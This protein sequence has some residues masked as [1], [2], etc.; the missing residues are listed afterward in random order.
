MLMTP[1]GIAVIAYVVL[2]V[3]CPG[4]AAPRLVLS[5]ACGLIAAGVVSFV[6]LLLG[7]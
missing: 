7:R 2:R 6:M 1:L 4:P 3:T 5:V